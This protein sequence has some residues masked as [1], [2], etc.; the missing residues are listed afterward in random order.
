M[1]FFPED[2]HD[3]CFSE[4]MN[5]SVAAFVDSLMGNWEKLGNIKN[6]SRGLLKSF[7]F[8]SLRFLYGILFLEIKHPLIVDAVEKFSTTFSNSMESWEI[9][10]RGRGLP[11]IGLQL[12]LNFI[13]L[14][15]NNYSPIRKGERKSPFRIKTFT[16]ANWK[17]FIFEVRMDLQKFIGYWINN[18]CQL[19]V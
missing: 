6:Q 2:T 12:C 15:L 14:S 1:D 4:W 18:S 5:F 13:H 8:S 11:R 16:G 3:N 10:S 7:S 17:S 9:V 19:I